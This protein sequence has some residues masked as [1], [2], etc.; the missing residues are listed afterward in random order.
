MSKKAIEEAD[1]I[2]P[3]SGARRRSTHPWLSSPPP[4]GVPRSP[5]LPGLSAPPPAPPAGERVLRAMGL[6]PRPVRSPR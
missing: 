6:G 3:V 4:S 5:T 1:T 2:P